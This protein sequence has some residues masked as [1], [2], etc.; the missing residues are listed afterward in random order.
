MKVAFVTM[1]YGKE[2]IGGAEAFCRIIAEHMSRQWKIDVLTTT[3]TDHFTWEKVFERGKTM[4]DNVVV[5]RFDIDEKKN[6]ARLSELGEKLIRGTFQ[7]TDELDW[8][9]TQGPLSTPLFSYIKKNRERYDAFLFWGYLFAHTYYGLPLVGKRAVLI[10]FI[11][12]EPFFYFHVYDKIFKK[13]GGFI[14]QTPEEKELLYR[15]RPAVTKKHRIVGTAI[16]VPDDISAVKISREHQMK[17]PYVVYVG[18]IEPAKGVIELANWF[19]RYK[20]KNPGNL[21]LVL[22]GNRN[23]EIPE[24]DSLVNLGPVFGPEKFSLMNKALVLINPSPFESFSLVI[25]EAWK[26]GV[27]VLV[28]GQCEVLKGQCRRANGGLWYEN[29]DEFEAMLNLLLENSS[30]RSQMAENGQKYL[31][32][33]YT[34]PVIE[35]KYNEVVDEVIKK[36]KRQR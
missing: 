2:V 28:N 30:L 6:L 9:N 23:N 20:E 8:I 11:H 17:D 16:D 27:P 5:R 21:K 31:E 14:F 10:P 19:E 36:S 29:Y 12:D 13:T 34:W 25:A 35:K 33:N 22:V 24:S 7:K 26:A 32:S 4:E 15:T 18:R 1:R 3:S